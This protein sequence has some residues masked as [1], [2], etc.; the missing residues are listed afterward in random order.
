MVRLELYLNASA[1]H[2][3]CVRAL[4]CRRGI[5]SSGLVTMN[6]D[7]SIL[8]IF[9]LLATKLYTRQPTKR[10]THSR[11]PILS[12]S[13]IHN[14]TLQTSACNNIYINDKHGSKNQQV[15]VIANEV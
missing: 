5:G 15:I 8:A 3:R 4:F 11:D 10:T 9:Q 14:I 12:V 7:E 1:L 6:N 2:V 13:S